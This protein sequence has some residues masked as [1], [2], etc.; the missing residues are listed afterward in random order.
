MKEGGLNLRPKDERRIEVLIRIRAGF[1]GVPEAGRLLGLGER[2]VSG[3]QSACGTE[4]PRGTIHGNR[5]RR[6]KRGFWVRRS[7]VPAPSRAL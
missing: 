2:Q 5:G 3:L 1:L 6:Q 7:G 4:G